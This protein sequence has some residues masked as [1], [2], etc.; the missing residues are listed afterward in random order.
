MNLMSSFTCTGQKIINFFFYFIKF[1]HS[2]MIS[3]RKFNVNG[4]STF[5]SMYL[6][7]IS[8]FPKMFLSSAANPHHI[9][10]NTQEQCLI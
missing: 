9:L 4:R 6:P 1:Y 2:Y 7:I 8:E 3:M 5:T 10:S